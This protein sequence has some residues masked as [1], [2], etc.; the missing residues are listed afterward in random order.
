VTVQTFTTYPQ[1]GDS[2]TRLG[3]PAGASIAADLLAIDNFVDDL[4]TR[5]TAARAGY[6]DNLATAPPTAS[7]I[8]AELEENGASVLD[9]IRDEIQSA[10]YGL[11]AIKVLVDD[12]EGRLTSARAGYLDELAAANIP[13]DVDT[14]LAR[15][16]ALRAGYLDNLSGGA[17]ALASGVNLVDGAI[18]ANKIATGAID[19][20]AIATD[21]VDEIT[22][23]IWAEVLDGSYTAKQ[24]I[25]L[26]VAALSGKSNGGG[27]STHNYRDLADAK[28]RIQATVDSS[29]NRTAMTLDVS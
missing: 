11:S 5:L 3:S 22:D 6:L 20:D 10:T 18:T 13:A 1:T 9:T 28:N 15:I 17:V 12:L 7:Q 2:Y 25:R 8:Q 23:S 16:T 19:A 21:A 26:M 24:I 14:L 29:G 27:T 4:E